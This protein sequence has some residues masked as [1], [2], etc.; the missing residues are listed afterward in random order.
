MSTHPVTSSLDVTVPFTRAE[1]LAA[2]LTDR[3]LRTHDFQSLMHGIYLHSSIR[4][5]PLIRARAAILAVKAPEAN[6]SHT[7]AARLYDIPIPADADEHV[8]VRERGQRTRRKGLVCHVAPREGTHWFQGLLVSTP[9]RTFC[10]LASMFGLVDVVVAGDHLVR[11]KLT[12]TTRLRQAVDASPLPRKAAAIR[13]AALVRARVDSP[14]ESRFRLLLRFGG[15]PEP[16]V[17]HEVRSD[18]GLLLRRHDL[19]VPERRLAFEILGR[20]HVDVVST[21]EKDVDREEDSKIDGWR[22]TNVLASR[23]YT[24]PE[25]VLR[26]TWVAM[27]QCGVRGVPKRLSEDWRRH[28][29]R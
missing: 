22:V 27:Q 5:T 7:T 26:Q 3:A 9:E 1:A 14:A 25:K 18:D 13:A 20:H 23:L 29:G 8:S 19:A 2:G 4:A 21:W 12:T 16:V 17:N 6:I 28:F 15:L 24:D 10:E 11:Q